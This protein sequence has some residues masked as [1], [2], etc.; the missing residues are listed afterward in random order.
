MLAIL[1]MAAEWGANIFPCRFRRLSSRPDMPKGLESPA[2][3]QAR[4]PAPHHSES[5]VEVGI[6]GCVGAKC[7]IFRHT[8]GASVE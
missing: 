4:E 8:T 5:G 2:N 7:L 3:R 1:S 6:S